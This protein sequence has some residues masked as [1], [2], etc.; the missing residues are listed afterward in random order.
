MDK[1]IQKKKKQV[2]ILLYENDLDV[3][4][5]NEDEIEVVIRDYGKFTPK[6][7]KGEPLN[8]KPKKTDP[9][10]GTYYEEVY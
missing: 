9:K 2:V 8:K 10:R 7:F 6:D 3:Y 5:P 1:K 4:N